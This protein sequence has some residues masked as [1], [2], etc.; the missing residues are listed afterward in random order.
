MQA[1]CQRPAQ[2]YSIESGQQM[3][4][5]MSPGGKGGLP[6][7]L[8]RTRAV[9][10]NVNLQPDPVGKKPVRTK[11]RIQVFDKID[12]VHSVGAKTQAAYR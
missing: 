5:R 2:G 3:L 12:S 10:V 6:A 9:R 4:T 7:G 8:V 1:V 11:S